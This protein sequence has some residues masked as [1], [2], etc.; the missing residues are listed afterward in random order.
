MGDEGMHYLKLVADQVFWNK[1]F[2]WN[3]VGHNE[4]ENLMFHLIFSQDFD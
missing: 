4:M 2:H 3:L 1:S